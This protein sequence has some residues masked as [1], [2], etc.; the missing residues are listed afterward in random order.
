VPTTGSRPQTVRFPKTELAPGDRKVVHVGRREIVV[1]NVD[2]D[3]YAIFNRCPH[4]QAKL[5]Q[6][7]LAGT[8]LPSAEVGVREYG[9]H[10][11]VLR[12]PWHHFEYDLTT[13]T[14]LADDHFRVRTYDVSED[15]DEVVLQVSAAR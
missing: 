4:H 1:F 13:G 7:P 6:G 10:G 9:L 12:C 15:G 11:R 8:S 2:G 5:D 14:C 3:Y